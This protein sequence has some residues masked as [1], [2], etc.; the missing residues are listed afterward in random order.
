MVKVLPCQKNKSGNNTEI[1]VMS[2]ITSPMLSAH[3]APLPS[4]GGCSVGVLVA[5]GHYVMINLC[6][7]VGVLY[8]DTHCC[9]SKATESVICIRACDISRI[10]LHTCLFGLSLICQNWTGLFFS[11]LGKTGY[12]RSIHHCNAWLCHVVSYRLLYE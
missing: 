8:L 10:Q 9:S 7:E 6:K 11:D 5:T 12:S 3:N 1:Y 2:I 4:V